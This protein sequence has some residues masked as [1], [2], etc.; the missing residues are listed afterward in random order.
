MT[1]PHEG[2][3]FEDMPIQKSSKC[4]FYAYAASVSQFTTICVRIKFLLVIVFLQRIQN[5]LSSVIHHLKDVRDLADHFR[6][7]LRETD[8]AGQGKE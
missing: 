2:N 5:L 3:C 6:S 8:A 4:Y 7:N 1:F